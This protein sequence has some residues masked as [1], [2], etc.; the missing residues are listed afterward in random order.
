MRA[1]GSMYWIHQAPLLLPWPGKWLVNQVSDFLGMEVWVYLSGHIN[2]PF[3]WGLGGREIYLENVVPTATTCANSYHLMPPIERSLSP[4][5]SYE[6]P[7]RIHLGNLCSSLP[8]LCALLEGRFW[9]FSVDG[10]RK[11]FSPKI[12]KKLL[13]KF[14]CDEVLRLMSHN[15]GRQEHVWG[16]LDLLVFPSMRTTM[17]FSSQELGDQDWTP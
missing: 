14:L 17:N 3:R 7:L 6:W 1:W 15:E 13:Y 8:H 9:Y 11:L 5:G 2:R 12:N 10:K 4:R 16:S